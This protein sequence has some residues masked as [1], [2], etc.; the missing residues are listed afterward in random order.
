LIY[1]F[2]FNI[3]WINFFDKINDDVKTIDRRL[4]LGI[5]GDVGL[6]YDITDT[7]YLNIGTALTYN[8]LNYRT[9]QSTADNWINTR[10][11]SSG[12]TFNPMFGIRPYFA[13]GVNFYSRKAPLQ[14]GNPK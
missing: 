13:I 12:W 9:A 3:N 11:D 2:G 8:F 5:G 6:K 4:G 1:G 10:Q 7:V 14:W